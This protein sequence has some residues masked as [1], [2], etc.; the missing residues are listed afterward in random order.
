MAEFAFL[1]ALVGYFNG[2]AGLAPPP[3]SVGIIDPADADP[4]PAIVLSLADLHR[5][6]IGLAGGLT[7]IATGALEVTATIDLA[8]PVLSGPDPVQLLDDTRTVLTLPHG[9]LIRADALDG[10][11]GPD[12]LAVTVDGAPVTLVAGAPGAGEIQVDPTIGQLTFGDALPAAGTLIAT[13]HLGLWERQTVTLTGTLILD[14]WGDNAGD[15]ADLSAAA[16]RALVGSNALAGLKSA[17][18]IHIES[19]PAGIGVN[20]PRRRRTELAFEYEHITDRPVSSGGIIASIPIT[21]RTPGTTR[22]PDTGA[23]IETIAVETD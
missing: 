3:A 14:V 2:P 6:D 17:R 15:L 19:I 21:T 16:V 20:A 23:V 22:D 9:G 7:E 12:D 4:M 10:A 13:Y 1:D 18:P 11:L 8:D 5:L